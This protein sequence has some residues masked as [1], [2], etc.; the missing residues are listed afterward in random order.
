MGHS[1]PPEPP[2]PKAGKQQKFY[3]GIIGLL[4]AVLVVGFVGYA[5]YSAIFGDPAM[6]PLL[7][8]TPSS[9]QNETSGGGTDSQPE[10]STSPVPDPGEGG[11][12]EISPT[13]SGDALIPR[14]VYSKVSPSVV[15]I[16]TTI[17]D[18]EGDT[19]TDQGSGIV[20]TEN[21][22]IITNSHVVG[23]SRNTEVKVVTRD[24]VEYIAWSWDM[25][26]PRTW[27]LS[28]S[29]RKI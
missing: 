21:G 11:T 26:A 8:D 15:G 18:S 23:D 4:T 1:N 24:K 10:S 28:K 5:A 19:S 2:R 29:M 17:T 6:P 16:V 12:I 7:E 20:A 22:Y 14:D 27:P 13:P 9:S 25:T 3:L